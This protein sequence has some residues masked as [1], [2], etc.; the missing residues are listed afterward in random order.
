MAAVGPRHCSTSANQAQRPGG[1]LGSMNL[2]HP[3]GQAGCSLQ[4]K[5]PLSSWD[6]PMKGGLQTP[7]LFTY[8]TWLR[9]SSNHWCLIHPVAQHI[10][11]APSSPSCWITQ[12]VLEWST[13]IPEG[14]FIRLLYAPQYGLHPCPS[15]L[16]LGFPS[17]V[18]RSRH[19]P[20]YTVYPLWLPG[21]I[22]TCSLQLQPSF[23]KEP[24]SCSSQA[25]R[26]LSHQPAVPKDTLTV[27][28]R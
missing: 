25:L 10:V 23:R 4:R 14:K 7:P 3:P 28:Q 12:H 21:A 26:L 19:L 20:S 5:R 6:V 27:Q 16:S 24:I 15:F 9:S 1:G 2:S 13:Q 8:H 22:K 18:S 11:A 17:A